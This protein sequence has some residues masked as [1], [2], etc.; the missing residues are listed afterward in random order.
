MRVIVRN[1]AVLLSGRC[2]C[3]RF[4][5]KHHLI[6]RHARLTWRSSWT[7]LIRFLRRSRMTC[8]LA[9][10]CWPR[11]S[12]LTRCTLLALPTLTLGKGRIHITV[13]VPRFV[14]VVTAII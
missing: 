14:I 3:A 8:W 10:V 7:Y 6:L 4:A 1:T 13:D 11:L 5:G 2:H 9:L 12:T